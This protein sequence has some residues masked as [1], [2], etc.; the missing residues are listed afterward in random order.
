MR[1]LPA[2]AQAG[3]WA[4]AHWTGL[5]VA[6]LVIAAATIRT[7][8]DRRFAAPV[9]LCD[10]FIY[11]NL[12][13]NLAQ[14]GRYL[15]RGAPE[16][17][18]YAYPLMLAPA[19]FAHSMSTTY[20]LAKGITTS[21]M[22]LTPIP[23]YLW[24]RRLATPVHAL[25]AAALTLLL[26]ALFYSG[27]LMTE[28]A[29]L[30]AFV[31]AV[32]AIALALE[33]PTLFHQLAALAA[34]ALAVS[35]R[36]Q[37]V[38][39]FLVIPTAVLAKAVLDLRAGDSR[40]RI[41]AGLRRLWPTAVLLG[42]G[43]LAYVVYKQIQGAPLAT[44]LGEYQGLA[45]AHYPLGATVRWAVKHLAELGL[46]VGL[47][48]VSAL[49]VLLWLGLRG[50]VTTSAERAFLAVV[51]ASMLWVL[52]EVGGFAAT[53]TPFVFERYTFY[54]E[55]LLMIAFVLWLAR[56]LPRPLL[57]TAVAVAVPALLVRTL[58]FNAFVVPDPV[59]GITLD[60]LFK[61]SRHLPGALEELKWAVAAGAL[62]GA[63]LFAVSARSVARVALPLL[64]AAYL[65]AASKPAF[66]DTAGASVSTRHSAGPVPSWIEKAIGRNK[67]V[68]YLNTPPGNSVTLLETEFWNRNVSAIYNLG[69]GEIC[70][71][72]ETSAAIAVATGRV[73]PPA[74]NGADYAVVD[75]QSLFPGHL[76]AL[77]GPNEYPLAL[78][79]IKRPLRVG[80]TTEGVATDGW[81]GE[82]AAFS[83]FGSRTNRPVRVTVTLGRAGWGG[84][85]V[86]GH[87]RIL[88]GKPSAASGKLVK[89]YDVRRWVVHRLA[90]RT[91]T[92]DARPPVRVEV[93]IHP[94]FSP[95][96]F[97]L[98]DTRQL[99]AQVSFAYA[100]VKTR[101]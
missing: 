95:S 101:H 12:A 29:F 8:L 10:E 79:Q 69:P 67:R 34:I 13:K 74:S 31:L 84:A 76:V 90:Q 81:M 44:G 3:R 24:A 26:P 94:T 63:F 32:F 19:W 89:V 72:P 36:V 7:V 66:D 11:A 39:L 42:G 71:L 78:Y 88:V 45:T 91:F 21:T 43:L 51:S 59:N 86:P 58:N 53:V 25:L 64:L 35:I 17:Q 47:V 1:R 23:V 38:V 4:L 18:S 2:P 46:A 68:L 6:V 97:G 22:A 85:D 82:S 92:F 100:P 56:G 49:I 50:A 52:V 27:V 48:P 16:H 33:R 65:V 57:G 61:F 87:V 55:P 40:D 30:P 5:A 75:R 73:D 41:L 28:G 60:S 93:H 54:L 80:T 77:G 14:H 83:V 98:A 20:A 99:G 9:V 70:S 96:Q 15:F 37:G 62:L